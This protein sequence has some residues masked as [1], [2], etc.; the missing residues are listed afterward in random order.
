[1]DDN[2]QAKQAWLTAL[3]LLSASPKTKIELSQ[4]LLDRGY[5]RAIIRETLDKLEE[6]G[7]INDYNYALNLVSKY[8]FSKPSGQRKIAFE[9]KRHG[10]SPK[11]CED[12][13]SRIGAT[14]E[15]ERAYGLAEAKW[16]R[17]SKLAA[18]QR[19]KR[20]YDFLIRRGFDFQTAKDV[21]TRL[22]VGL[23]EDLL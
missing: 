21:L 22:G 19:K 18:P 3:R 14:E 17:L 6:R 4:K 2:P 5:S 11:V 16:C 12:V 1:M 23:A 7:I 15:L 10:I 20:V 8:R 13:L 9:L